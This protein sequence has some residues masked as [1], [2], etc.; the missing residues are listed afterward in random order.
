MMM[1]MMMMMINLLMKVSGY[2]LLQLLYLML[3]LRSQAIINA[4][5]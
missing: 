4:L 1:M 3:Y 2:L 5:S